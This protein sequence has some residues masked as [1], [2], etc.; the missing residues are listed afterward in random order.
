MINKEAYSQITFVNGNFASETD[1][2]YFDTNHARLNA[3]GVELYTNYSSQVTVIVNDTKKVEL[4]IFNG[5]DGLLQLLGLDAKNPVS[6]VLIDIMFDEY[7]MKM[8]GEG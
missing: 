6:Y 7:S 2:T 5:T 3:V 1:R 8:G 4:S